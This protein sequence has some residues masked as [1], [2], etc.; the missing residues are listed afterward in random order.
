MTA[1]NRLVVRVFDLL[2]APLASL[3]PFGGLAI[4]SLVTAAALLLAFKATSDQRRLAAVKRSIHA[5][6]FEIRL[7]ADDI[8]TLLRAQVGMLHASLVYLRL[9]LVPALWVIL[10]IAL[11]VSHLEFHFGYNGLTRGHAALLTATLPGG[12]P[13][14]KPVVSLDAPPAV[15]V[16]T[17]AVWL[18]G[19]GEVVWRITPIAE[20]EH[21]LHV[22]IGDQVLDKTVLVSGAVRRRSPARFAGG[23]LDQM[24]YPSEDPLPRQA[25]VTSISIDYAS[26]DIRVLRWNMNWLVLY[27]ALTIVFMMAL[28]RR[29]GV[30]L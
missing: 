11:V 30:V 2:L 28:R 15:R 3:P 5:G 24:M 23:V 22:H 26:R 14:S 27:V 10:P 17:P 9:S 19:A 8:P 12:A 16:D 25:G 1:L 6:F 21:V 13:V 29:F 7:F 4:V 20:G 18:P